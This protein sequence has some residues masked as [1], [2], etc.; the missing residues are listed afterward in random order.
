MTDTKLLQIPYPQKQE[1]SSK[2]AGPGSP[3]LG[4]FDYEAMKWLGDADGRRE[5]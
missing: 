3:R 1:R 4:R 2:L 5:R